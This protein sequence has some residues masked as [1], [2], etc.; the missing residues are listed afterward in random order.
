M[1]S[2]LSSLI[3]S[4]KSTKINVYIIVECVLKKLGTQ[5]KKKIIYGKKEKN[6]WQ[7]SDIDTA[8]SKAIAD[9]GS[10]ISALSIHFF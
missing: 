5:G 4:W 6:K 3:D 10:I 8:K 1:C 2:N 7:E 9:L